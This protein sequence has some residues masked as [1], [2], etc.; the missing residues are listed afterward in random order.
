MLTVTPGTFAPTPQTAVI[1]WRVD[2][3]VIPGATGRTLRLNP[4][5]VG[6]T[7]TALTIAR[8]TAS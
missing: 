1:Q 8:A 6:K 4:A 5:L 3:E 7:I 2:G